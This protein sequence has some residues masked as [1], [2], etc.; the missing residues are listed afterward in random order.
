LLFFIGCLPDAPD[1][2]TP[3]VLNWIAVEERVVRRWVPE[4]DAQNL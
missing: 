4:R 1:I 2:S 3:A